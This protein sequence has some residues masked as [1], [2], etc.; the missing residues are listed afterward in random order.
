MKTTSAQSASV[1]QYLA[2]VAREPAVL[3]ADRRHELGSDLAEHIE[4]ELAERPGSEA[5][6]LRELGDPRVPARPTG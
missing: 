2:A 4:T 1:R 3:P 6:I 5:E